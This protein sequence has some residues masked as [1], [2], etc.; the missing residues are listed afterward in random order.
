[1]SWGHEVCLV[2]WHMHPSS[3]DRGG[4]WTGNKVPDGENRWFHTVCPAEA[5]QWDETMGP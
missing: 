3:G 5:R 1:M 2:T 4:T